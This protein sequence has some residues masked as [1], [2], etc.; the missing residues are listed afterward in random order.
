MS[1]LSFTPFRPS[2]RNF[3]IVAI[4]LALV[5][6]VAV[7]FSPPK[8]AALRSA[9]PNPVADSSLATPPGSQTAVFAGGCF[10]GME[11]LF[12]HVEGVSSVVSGYTGGSAETAHYKQVSGGRTGHA[13]SVN[14]T[15]DPSQVSY[16]QLLKVFFTVAH[17]PTQLNQQ[18][19]DMGT[20]YR[21]AIF[22]TQAEQKQIAQA[23]IEQLNQ[24]KV[25]YQPIVT[26]VE[27]VDNF[28][29]AEAYH[30]QYV[31]QH[32]HNFYV[33]AVELPKID[34]FRKRFPD[35]YKP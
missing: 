5:G 7:R 15:Y 28:Y 32:P 6:F 29:S 11:A 25:F 34:R 17:D 18:G 19:F 16:G 3:L 14:I 2:L 31:E 4:A 10:W 27:P 23:Y 30:Q 33:T 21:S 35:L 26:Q 13:E 20:Q 12:E 8:L 1:G 9:V 22:F 24:A